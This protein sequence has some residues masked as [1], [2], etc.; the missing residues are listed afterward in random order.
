MEGD[1]GPTEMWSGCLNG[2]GSYPFRRG[3]EMPPV[4]RTIG[5]VEEPG[6]PCTSE[7][8]SLSILLVDVEETTWWP[9]RAWYF[10]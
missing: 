8:N 1:Q 5:Q 4:G 6:Q 9:V 7:K 2:C 3:M 10:S